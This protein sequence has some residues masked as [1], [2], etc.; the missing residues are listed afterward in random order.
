MK[1]LC[2]AC[3]REIS[4]EQARLGYAF[5]VELLSL[6]EARAL[7]PRCLRCARHVL[8]AARDEKQEEVRHAASR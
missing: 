5:L 1:L 7:S 3:N 6:A 2:V 8:D 4:S